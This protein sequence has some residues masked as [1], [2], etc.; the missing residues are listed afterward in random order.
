MR[1]KW[2]DTQVRCERHESRLCGKQILPFAGAVGSSDSVIRFRPSAPLRMLCCNRSR[3]TERL[4]CLEARAPKPFV[5][6]NLWRRLSGAKLVQ[7]PFPAHRSSEI[8]HWVSNPRIARGRSMNWRRRVQR[9]QSLSAMARITQSSITRLGFQ[10]SGSS[11]ESAFS[12][13]STVARP[14][15][16]A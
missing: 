6:R 7:D 10:T 1:R 11:A 12:R 14:I 15:V 9:D 3:Q 16:S 8:R 2:R 4:G 5:H 13:S